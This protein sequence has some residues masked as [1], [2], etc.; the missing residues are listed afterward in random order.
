MPTQVEAHFL[1]RGHPGLRG[2]LGCNTHRNAYSVSRINHPPL[3]T[4]GGMARACPQGLRG[5]WGGFPLQMLNTY[6]NSDSG[7][8][9][10]PIGVFPEKNRL[11]QAYWPQ[12]AYQQIQDVFFQKN[13]APAASLLA[14][15]SLY[16]WFGRGYWVLGGGM[17]KACP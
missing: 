6:K 4:Q 8:S 9:T 15:K 7:M 5:G 3:G 14:T 13:K 11:W 16:V 17:G 12:K 1:T 2:C 10:N